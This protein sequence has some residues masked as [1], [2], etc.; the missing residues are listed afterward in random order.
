V[1]ILGA[2][3]VVFASAFLR[4]D[5]ISASDASQTLTSTHTGIDFRWEG[6]VVIVLSLLAAFVGAL[7]ATR[8][9]GYRW[10]FL[11]GILALGALGVLL[12][13]LIK[14][15]NINV[16][17]PRGFSL[18]IGIGYGLWIGIAASVLTVAL[19]VYALLPPSARAPMQVAR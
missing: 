17:V 10:S 19:C 7:I 15:L 1:L 18:E 13:R 9:V 11:S 4:W 6:T 8:I 14:V 12:Y 2:S 5:R 3:S 16:P